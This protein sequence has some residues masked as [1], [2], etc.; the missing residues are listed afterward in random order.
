V[1]Y[2]FRKEEVRAKAGVI[3]GLHFQR[4]PYAQGKL[5][6]VIRGAILDVAVDIRI[7]S[8]TYGQH[9]AAML[10]AQNWQQLWVPFGF[11]HGYCILE[12]ETEVIYKASNYYSP[13]D[14]LGLA[15]DDPALAIAWPVAAETALLSD[16][17]RYRPETSRI[18]VL[19][20]ICR[21]RNPELKS[22]I[23]RPLLRS[24][25]KSAVWHL[26]VD[27][28]RLGASSAAGGGTP[29]RRKS[30]GARRKARR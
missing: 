6:R 9:V 12:A 22:D 19:F 29:G 11:A 14:D 13:A 3:R 2:R 15:F 5:V 16:R 30:C 23:C 7:G 8:P 20:P 4:P 26:G 27:T 18:A 28:G 25:K 17:D 24:E 1:G 21:A 10:S